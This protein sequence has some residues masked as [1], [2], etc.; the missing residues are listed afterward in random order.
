[1]IM[2]VLSSVPRII[3]VLPKRFIQQ[4]KD[5]AYLVELDECWLYTSDAGGAGKTALTFCVGCTLLTLVG[6]KKADTKIAL[7]V[8]KESSY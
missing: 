6:R 5:S 3:T 2:I 8:E 4:E 1:M 7:K